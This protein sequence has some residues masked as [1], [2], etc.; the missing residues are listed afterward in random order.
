M[1]QA[2]LPQ[3]EQIGTVRIKTEILYIH[4]FYQQNHIQLLQIPNVQAFLHLCGHLGPVFGK[5]DLFNRLRVVVQDL[6]NLAAGLVDQQIPIS[7]AKGKEPAVW[8][9][10]CSWNLG[11]RA[12]HLLEDEFKSIVE[13]DGW[14]D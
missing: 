3:H 8:M 12:G 11:F 13:V 9:Y 6:H 2:L 14:V 5:S 10:C 4:W 7:C 1:L